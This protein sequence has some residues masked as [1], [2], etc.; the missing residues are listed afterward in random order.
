MERSP[1]LGNGT[2]V[3]REEGLTDGA[4]V[5]RIDRLLVA[6]RGCGTA[7]KP[8][9]GRAGSL[10]GGCGDDCARIVVG[11]AG[12]R[13]VVC[14]VRHGEVLRRDDVGWEVKACKDNQGR[15]IER[16]VGALLSWRVFERGGL[17]IAD[18]GTGLAN[19][20]A[21]SKQNTVSLLEDYD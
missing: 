9:G 3:G 17:P 13:E 8:V 10:V 20:R 4:R 19:A 1:E 11:S 6:R 5:R 18:G 15:M 7:E 12:L 21:G 2:L 16:R 14:R